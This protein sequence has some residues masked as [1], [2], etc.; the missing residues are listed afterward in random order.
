MNFLVLDLQHIYL[1][2]MTVGI[3]REGKNPPD[4]RVALTPQQCVEVKNRFN[5]NIIVQPSKIRAF[6]DQEYLNLGIN[7]QED[8]SSC[9]IL[10]GVKEVPEQDLIQ[11]KTYFFFSHTYKKQ[12]YNRTLINTILEKSISLVDYEM[13]TSKTGARLVA[14]G[15]Y[16]GIVGAYNALRGVG[17]RDKLFEIKPAYDCHDKKELYQEMVKI[18]LPKNYKIVVTGKGRVA[19]GALETLYAA[20]I[21]QVSPIDFLTKTFNQPVFTDLDVSRYNK[22]IDGSDFSREIFFAKPELFQSSFFQYAHVADAYIACHFWD[23]NAPFI[24][25]REEAKHPSFNLKF[26]ADISCDIDGPVASTIRPSTID[27]PFY[28]YNAVAEKETD[29]MNKNSIGVMAVDN[30][31]CELPRDASQY[32]GHDL[33]ENILPFLFGDDP[34]EVIYRATET[35]NGKLTP[36]FSYLEKYV[37]GEE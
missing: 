32:F 27:N 22:T 34:D 9:N 28:G 19:G 8:I 21:M 18:D 25:S 3:I 7:V 24:F 2:I 31:P 13:L 1:P 29:F 4:K 17:L 36:H 23:S 10:L 14:F 26:V 30:L 16:A 12:P 11:D 6:K 33:I 20:K 5:I 15:K 37:K 35:Q